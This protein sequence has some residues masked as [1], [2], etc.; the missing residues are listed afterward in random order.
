VLEVLGGHRLVALALEAVALVLQRAAVGR[1]GLR[2][3]PDTRRRLVDQVD[4][5]VGQEAVPAG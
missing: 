3:Q 2:P 5:L 4:G 1:L